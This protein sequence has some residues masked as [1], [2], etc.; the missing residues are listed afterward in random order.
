MKVLPC[1]GYMARLPRDYAA[2][3]E[4]KRHERQLRVNAS[5]NRIVSILESPRR[6]AVLR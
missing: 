6:P 1:P 5:F 3:E 2:C 4:G